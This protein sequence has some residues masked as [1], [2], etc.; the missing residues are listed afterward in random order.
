MIYFVI[1]E[2]T[3]GSHVEQIS[4]TIE[5]LRDL[6]PYDPIYVTEY[7]NTDD[8]LFDL[9]DY[10]DLNYKPWDGEVTINCYMYRGQF[11]E[12]LPDEDFFN[13][14]EE[15]FNDYIVTLH[16]VYKEGIIAK[17]WTTDGWI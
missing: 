6:Y 7:M 3:Q 16:R 8:T 14:D 13:E 4:T 10:S 1:G 2:T 5:Q 17:E 11:Y 9:L 15:S 12:N